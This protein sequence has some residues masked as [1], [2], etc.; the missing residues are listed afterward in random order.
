MR[1]YKNKIEAKASLLK[2]RPG[3]FGVFPIYKKPLRCKVFGHKPIDIYV[4]GGEFKQFCLRCKI[5]VALSD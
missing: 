5:L 2:K 1:K 3:S 4:G